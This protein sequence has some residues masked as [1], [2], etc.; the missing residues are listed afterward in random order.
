[1]ALRTTP[2]YDEPVPP[3]QRLCATVALAVVALLAMPHAAR[4]QSEA[5]EESQF[6]TALSTTA[7]SYWFASFFGGLMVPVGSMA[8]SHEQGLVAT[9]R[10]GF[11]ARTGIGF[12]VAGSYSPM[13]RRDPEDATGD[14]TVAGH[15]GVVSAAPRF[16]FGKRTVRFW[17]A[18]GGG[19]IV[20]R[21]TITVDGEDSSDTSF[22]PAAVGDAGLEL[23]LFANGGV[24]A[25]GSYAQSFGDTIDA[26]AA[27][28]LG[29]LVFTFD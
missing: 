8:D 26:R 22:E 21:S 14:T 7:T 25:S 2:R 12:H 23:H 15:V 11:T 17:L 24:V 16:T 4:A 27:S 9:V 6:D 20:E 28:A 18:A 5:G 29:G 19:G 1:M 3:S 10:F 13:P